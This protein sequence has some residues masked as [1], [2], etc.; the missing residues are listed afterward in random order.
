MSVVVLL[1]DSIFD[2]AR[3]VSP[4]GMPVIKQLQNVLQTGSTATL[5]AVDGS[6]TKDVIA[7]LKSIPSETTHLA[8]SSGGNDALG[9][10]KLIFS[11]LS[12]E[13][14]LETFSTVQHEFRISYERL[15][16]AAKKT[17]IPTMVCTI[18]DSVPGLNAI[19]KTLLSLF[20]DVIVFQASHAGFLI[21]DLRSLCTDPKDF[22]EISPI[23]PSAQGGMKTVNR[24]ALVVQDHSFDSSKYECLL[25]FVP[26]PTEAV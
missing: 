22:S 9:A 13:A 3:Y 5:L 18:Y 23:E 2:N 8:I 21:I 14:L 24:T 11:S 7:Q 26:G 19:E 6:I 12:S 16:S 15:I 20:N 4:D 1:D 17:R 10:R 25:G